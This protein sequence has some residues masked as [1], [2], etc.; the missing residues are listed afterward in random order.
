MSVIVSRAL[1]DV[2]DGLKPV[3]RRVLYGMTDLG[4]GASRPYKKSA[5]IVGEV[6]PKFVFVENTPTLVAGGLAVVI[7][8][9]AS[10]GYDARWGRIG[11]DISSLPHHRSRFW[12]VANSRSK[13]V[14]GNNKKPVQ[15]IKGLSGNKLSRRI[16]EIRRRPT[17]SKCFYNGV[18]DGIPNY[19]ERIKSLGNAQVPI[20][21]ATAFKILGGE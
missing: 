15:R 20:V 13:Y 1:P 2:R 21:A 9:L 19:V 12:L 5:R 10:M 16:E 3:Y 11:A 18:S 7:G 17:E 6:L 14:E 8:D 4:L